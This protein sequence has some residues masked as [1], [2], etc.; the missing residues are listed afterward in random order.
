MCMIVLARRTCHQV[1]FLMLWL[2]SVINY[3]SVEKEKT[4]KLKKKKKKKKYMVNVKFCTR[5]S[6]PCLYLHVLH[7][8]FN[9]NK[10]F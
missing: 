6:I 4:K 9:Y 7:I 8:N 2:I 5:N 1:N 10:A 3:T